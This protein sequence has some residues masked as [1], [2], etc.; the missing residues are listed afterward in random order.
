[1]SARCC[2]RVGWVSLQ[3][4]PEE[5]AVHYIYE[6]KA[7]GAWRSQTG[8]GTLMS[9]HATVQGEQVTALRFS[10]PRAT[11]NETPF[12]MRLN[13]IEFTCSACT[14]HGKGP[15][16]EPNVTPNLGG[17]EEKI[18]KG[19]SLRSLLFWGHALADQERPLTFRAIPFEGPKMSSRGNMYSKS[20]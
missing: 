16:R 7:S 10:K 2:T 15:E 18:L 12:Q 11:P 9:C 3:H 8:Q 6:A 1:M 19:E 4:P 5:G 14:Q 20:C 13:P 17:Y